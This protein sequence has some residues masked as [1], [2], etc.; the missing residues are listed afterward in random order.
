M[1]LKIVIKSWKWKRFPQKIKNF[2]Q[3]WY[4]YFKK[5][6]HIQDQVAWRIVTM[7]PECLHKKECIHCGCPIP[8]KLFAEERCI[9]IEECYKVMLSREEWKLTDKKSNKN[10]KKVAN[11][12][13]ERENY[14]TRIY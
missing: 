14:R 7:N 8:Q 5:T 11:E 13:L 9:E 4:H 1:N 10:I 2:F 6:D 12:I 3:G